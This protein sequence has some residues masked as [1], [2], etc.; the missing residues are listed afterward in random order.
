MLRRIGLWA[1]CGLAV[2]LAWA[3]VFYFAGPAFSQYPSQGAV[4]DDLGHT[5]WVPA[6]APVALL[7]H[8]YAITWYVSAVINAAIYAGIGLLFE[9]LRLAVRSGQ[10]SLR[11]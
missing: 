9:T 1:L 2:A 3:A 11:H 5:A 8:H 6:T 10:A 4:L 7:G